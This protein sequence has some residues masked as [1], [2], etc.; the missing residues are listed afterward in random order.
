M[1]HYELL[2]VNFDES[3]LPDFIYDVTGE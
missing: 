2:L 3:F 1:K